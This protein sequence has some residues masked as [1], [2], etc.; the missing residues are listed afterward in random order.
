[1]SEKQTYFLTGVTGTLGKE[2]VRELLITAPHE[3]YVLIRGQKNLSAR[4]RLRKILAASGIEHF[5]EKR[6]W[7]LEGDITRP[8]LGI[9]S[10]EMELLRAK[11]DRF[12]HVAAL[13]ALNGSREECFSINLG[14]TREALSVG[15]DFLKKG[16][17]KRFFY[18]STAYAAGSRQT[19]RSLESGL[20]ESPAHAN[21]Y[22]SS[23]YEAEKFVRQ[24]IAEGF[25]A[26]I[27][28]PSIVVG[29]SQTGAT[30]EFNVIYPFLKLFAHRILTKLPSRLENSFNIVPID[31]VI[32]AALA[33]AQRDD[34]L[35]R[36]Y[37]LVTQEPPTIGMLLDVA[38]QEYPQIPEVELIDP[39]R[40]EPSA[41]PPQEKFVYDMLTPYLGYLN[42]HLTFD[43]SDAQEALRGTGV[44]FPRTDR[45]FLK[46]L[47]AYAVDAGYL[48]VS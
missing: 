1:M 17:M 19:Y 28:R 20:P 29:H 3:L 4:E 12:M 45:G 25:P 42:D 44:D 6:I 16:K 27:F 48:L 39:D 47:L 7:A 15:W 9:S 31:F 37:H 43:T 33:I 8:G 40:F 22:E 36:G 32:K 24:A 46:R 34:S 38:R 30:S 13:T 18:F 5:F 11:T 14:G 35:G 10:E 23:K 2:L 26:T 41:L 21:F